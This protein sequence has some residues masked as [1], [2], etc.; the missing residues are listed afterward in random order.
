MS[1]CTIYGPREIAFSLWLRNFTR[2]DEGH[3]RYSCVGKSL[4]SLANSISSF[5]KLCAQLFPG[6]NARTID[7][8]IYTCSKVEWISQT[9]FEW[10]IRRRI[11]CIQEKA[12]A[13][14]PQGRPELSHFQRFRELQEPARYIGLKTRCEHRSPSLQPSVQASN[15][16]YVLQ[17][18][19]LFAIGIS[20]ASCLPRWI[21]TASEFRV[22]CLDREWGCPSACAFCTVENAVHFW[23]YQS[24]S[25]CELATKN[26]ASHIAIKTKITS[27]TIFSSLSKARSVHWGT[28]LRRVCVWTSP[29]GDWTFH[30][31]RKLFP[32]F[33]PGLSRFYIAELS[34][35]SLFFVVLLL[36]SSTCRIYFP[37]VSNF[38]F[39]RVMKTPCERFSKVSEDL[40]ISGGIWAFV[41]YEVVSGL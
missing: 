28:V 2:Q 26:V 39:I 11:R 3:P 36:S 25:H 31:L 18:R 4:Q 16:T 22:V 20:R 21:E 33:P 41:R 7:S 12:L 24:K 17:L 9:Q 8:E 37:R 6:D 40:R 5:R 30:L 34:Y 32:G 38:F 29:C 27:C 35:S 19:K 1:F 13:S 15:Q 14:R 10:C 23:R